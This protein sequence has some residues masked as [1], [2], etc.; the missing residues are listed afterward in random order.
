MGAQPAC[1]LLI[2][3]NPGDATLMREYLSNFDGVSVSLEH[4]D[5]LSLA[6]ERLKRGG[7]DVILLD[8]TLPDSHG[9]DT[10]DQVIAVSDAVP[11]LVLTGFDDTETGLAAVRKGAHD[12]LVKGRLTPSGIVRAVR[13]TI[14]RSRL[15]AERN[16]REAEFR[17]VMEQMPLAVWTTDRDLRCT[18]CFGAALT[19]VQVTPSDAVGKTPQEFF[20]TD[21]DEH[22]IIRAERE[23]LHGKSESFEFTWRNRTFQIRIRPLDFL[24]NHVIGTTG[25]AL[26]ITDAKRL[27]EDFLAAGKVQQKLLPKSAPELPGFEMAGICRPAASTGGDYFDYIPLRDGTLGLVIADVSNHGFAPSLIM[28]STRRLLRTLVTI[29][30]DLGEVLTDANAALKEDIEEHFVT[31]FFARLDPKART[32]S[33]V[34]AAHDAYIIS[35]RGDY[36]QLPSDC[37]PLGVEPNRITSTHPAIPL[38]SGSILILLTDGLTDAMAPDGRRFGTKRVMNTIFAHRTK[39][40]AEINQI[41]LDEAH[42]FC[43]PGVPHDDITMVIVKVK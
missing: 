17:L 29:H 12:F 27:E 11:V 20:F 39:S 33:Y 43:K 7:F 40:A 8:L 21:D 35:P 41:L 2:E 5:R 34:A 1:I 13:Y 37:L 6:L 24:G 22:P 36:R 32:L 15:E 3:D 4:V 31:L 26:D 25:I 23:A 9:L 38:E 30:E 16:R 10:V 14:E 19:G 42:H 28:A 18:S